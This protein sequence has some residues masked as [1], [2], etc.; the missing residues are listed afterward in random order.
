MI[1]YFLVENKED[2]IE[3]STNAGDDRSEAGD[4]FQEGI[5][6]VQG[7]D[8]DSNE[9]VPP[10]E[11]VTPK[12]L[13]AIDAR[14]RFE[15]DEVSSGDVDTK[16]AQ[17]TSQHMEDPDAPSETYSIASIPDMNDSQS[18]QDTIYDFNNSSTQLRGRRFLLLISLAGGMVTLLITALCFNIHESSSA[19]LPVIAFFIYVFTLFYSVGAGAIPFLYCAEV[20]LYQVLALPS[21]LSSSHIISVS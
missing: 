16:G 5:D 18:E 19:R 7:Q 13:S 4:L 6:S 9:K 14:V 8:F 3:M 20:C 15:Q 2:Q 11:A 21:L 10:S 1:A 17:S 12:R